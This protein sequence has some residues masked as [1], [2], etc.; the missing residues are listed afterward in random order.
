MNKVLSTACL[1]LLLMSA[2]KNGENRMAEIK[3]LSHLEEKTDGNW[4]VNLEYLPA[5][6]AKGDTMEYCFTVNIRAKDPAKPIEADDPKFS[7]GTDSLFCI[8]T[9]T[10]TLFPVF[11]TRVANGK[12]TGLQYMV[13]FDKAAVPEN[14]RLV[15]LFKDWLFTNR[16]LEFILPVMDIHTIDS[17]SL[18][19]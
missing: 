18:H 11:T 4:L 1:A 17:L 15:F 14:D 6:M 16:K 13:I 8:I 5:A 2:C 9:Q 10:D 19:I 3:D 12:L 7:F